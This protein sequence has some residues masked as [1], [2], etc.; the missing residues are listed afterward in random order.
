MI[1]ACARAT[2]PS[3]QAEYSLASVG[4]LRLWRSVF[5][6]SFSIKSSS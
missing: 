6:L 5:N 4:N 3:S 1:R 2:Q